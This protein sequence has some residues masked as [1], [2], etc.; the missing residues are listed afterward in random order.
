MG[1]QAGALRVKRKL[2]T[3]VGVCLVSLI[4]TQALFLVCLRKDLFE[5]KKMRA[6]GVVEAAYDMVQYQYSA[7]VPG[8]LTEQEARDRAREGVRSLHCNGDEYFWINDMNGVIVAH[9]Y[10]SWKAKIRRRERRQRE[11]YSRR[12]CRQGEG[13]EGRLRPLRVEAVRLRGSDA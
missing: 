8:A 13:G 9:P 12:F 2:W 7:A 11:K 3:I 5:E 10:L 1:S 4:L 6:K